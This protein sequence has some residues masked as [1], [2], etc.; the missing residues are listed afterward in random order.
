MVLAVP[1]LIAALLAI[2]ARD[3]TRRGCEARGSREWLATRASPLDSASLVVG[4]ATV[5]V[6]YSRPH[7][8]GRSVDSL[9]PMGQA[10]RTGANEPT[11]VTL[12]APATIG[13]AALAAG[14]YVVLTVPGPERWTLVFHTTPE[15]EPAR[16][17]ATLRAVA[18]GTGRV[19]RSPSP[20]EQFTIRAET[21][22]DAAALVLEW[23]DRRVR[24][25]VIAGP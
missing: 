19:E 11:T 1:V 16:M 14:R 9:V 7:A 18:Q 6:C 8:R 24:V 4:G 17:F 22:G 13:G 25:P 15:T 12:T 23:G 21:T 2:G 20:V 3:S 10:W 5:Q